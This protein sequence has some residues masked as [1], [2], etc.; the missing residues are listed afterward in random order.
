M[1]ELGKVSPEGEFLHIAL[2]DWLTMYKPKVESSMV[3]I[4]PLIWMLAHN[5]AL[6][7]TSTTRTWDL[8]TNKRDKFRIILFMVSIT[9]KSLGVGVRVI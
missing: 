6:L 9:I 5:F 1:N 8:S 7:P 2:T 4:K 3:I